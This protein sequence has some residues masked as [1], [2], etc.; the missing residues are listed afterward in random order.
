[1]RLVHGSKDTARLE[2]SCQFSLAGRV[3]HR[4]Y[5]D[6]RHDPRCGTVCLRPTILLLGACVDGPTE[7]CRRLT[8]PPPSPPR[9]HANR[10]TIIE[11]LR[12]QCKETS[13]T[14]GDTSGLAGATK[15]RLQARV[16]GV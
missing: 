7:P 2:C 3:S 10:G 14:N 5:L 15:T 12:P 16:Y 1:M 11:K 13:G 8:S 6:G 4:L 9:A